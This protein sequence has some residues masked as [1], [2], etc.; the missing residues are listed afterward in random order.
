MRETL[1]SLWEEYYAEKCAKIET[2]EERAL[3]KTA[4]EKREIMRGL[5]TMEQGVALENY[6]EA[7]YELQIVFLKKAFLKGCRFLTSFFR[8]TG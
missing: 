8:E 3:A 7:L 1:E 5:L 6:I 4:A 2:E